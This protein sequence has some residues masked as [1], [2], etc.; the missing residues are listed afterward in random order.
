MIS[1]VSG[2]SPPPLPLACDK[3][4]ALLCPQRS[5][6]SDWP[7]YIYTMH[8]K[9]KQHAA[10]EH[11]LAVVLTL[12]GQNKHNNNVKPVLWDMDN[13]VCNVV[14]KDSSVVVVLVVIV[15]TASSYLSNKTNSWDHYFLMDLID[16][17][18]NQLQNQDPR[19]V[20]TNKCQ[21]C[22]CSL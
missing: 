4:A 2:F 1:W 3:S 18:K 5:A 17:S 11:P 6:H 13:R 20:H 21:K 9:V 10:E 15:C 14:V 22:G 7:I 16:F 8:T 19:I 12:F